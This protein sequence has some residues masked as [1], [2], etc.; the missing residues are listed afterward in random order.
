MDSIKLANL[1]VTDNHLIDAVVEVLRSGKFI[2]GQ[3]VLDF[4]RDWAKI[5]NSKYCISTS[6]GTMALF[7]MMRVLR[8]IDGVPK[9]ERPLVILPGL[10]YAAT[11][12]AVQEAGFDVIFCDVDKTG[13]IDMKFCEAI[14]R[15]H[16][17]DIY[18]IPVHLYGQIVN[19]DHGFLEHATIVEDAA[20]VH[21]VF[22]K[23]TGDA[24]CFSFYPS[25]NLGG[26]GDGGALVTDDTAIYNVARMYGNLGDTFDGKYDHIISG[27]NLRMDT[28]QAAF[29]QA[30]LKLGSLDQELKSRK[31]QAEIYREHGI[32]TIATVQP[33]GY[34]L[35]PVLFDKPDK[36]IKLFKDREIDV[37]RHYPYALPE[38]GR[39]GVDLPNSIF[40]AQHN[41]TLP[42]GSHLI[43][44]QI[45][46]VCETMLSL[47]ELDDYGKL[48]TLK[49]SILDS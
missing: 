12:Y 46:Y 7:S 26:L 44:S 47:F 13:L 2:R 41:V 17:D 3:Q 35:Y 45:E 6:S 23:V 42:L 15:E 48:W 19:L 21:G 34:H 37:G 11:L 4:E 14:V 30:K 16:Y 40:I 39:G 22:T 27:L 8:I 10:S 29:L 36:L 32:E 20:Q 18:L 25:K 28:I 31:R 24:A 38:L 43:E 49:E 9:K 33:N 1:E 5:C